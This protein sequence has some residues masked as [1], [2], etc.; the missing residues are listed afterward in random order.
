LPNISGVTKGGI[1]G[2]GQFP[3]GTADDEGHKNSLTENISATIKL[4]LMKFAE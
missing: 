3:P 2:G 4:S 1:E